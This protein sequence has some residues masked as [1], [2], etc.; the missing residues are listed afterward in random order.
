MSTIQQLRQK[1]HRDVCQSV[2]Y[3]KEG[4]IPSI[5]DV[6]N[7]L[8]IQLARRV[9]AIVECPLGSQVISGQTAGRHFEL[10]TRD[11]L[12]AAF[13][14]LLHIRPGQRHFSV[15]TSIANYAQY[16]HLARVRELIQSSRELRTALGDYVVT[17]D[18]IVSRLPISDDELNRHEPLVDPEGQPRYTPLRKDVLSDPRPILH[19]SISYK[20]TL[21]SDRSQNARTEGLNL[22][23]NRKGNTPHIVVVTAE[24]LPTRTASLA[25]GTGD[26]D[27]VYHF[28]LPELAQAAHAV[29]NEA[30]IDSL[31]ELIAGDRLRDISDLPFDLAI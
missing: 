26:I 31:E 8:S 25:L 7:S 19:A 11:F 18:I 2:I 3:A 6:S 16:A 1:Y 5:A 22:I 15:E 28:A 10:T 24:P 12:S 14:L 29:G 20:L 23:R 9:F 27:C 13:R 4:D 30:I 21:R 17:P